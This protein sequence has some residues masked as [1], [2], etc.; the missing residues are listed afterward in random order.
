MASNA[1]GSR[2]SP[3]PFR[4]KYSG[5]TSNPLFN[6][7]NRSGLA[8]EYPSLHGADQANIPA[9]LSA[10][11][12]AEGVPP[13]NHGG[14][15]YIPRPPDP[16]LDRLFTGERFQQNGMGIATWEVPC[17]QQALPRP[18]G[19]NLPVNE[20]AWPSFFERE[21][22]LNLTTSPAH[23]TLR[24]VIIDSPAVWAELR[25]CIELATRLLSLVSE[26]DW[27]GPAIATRVPP[28]TP[29]R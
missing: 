11:I 2:R 23:P 20:S 22:W 14:S 25:Q 21:R 3:S 28:T 29:D 19:P 7:L 17:M 1:P 27:Y 5:G 26:T 10:A 6:D 8:P 9:V 16:D 18:D 24:S 4:K 13:A 12:K 15:S